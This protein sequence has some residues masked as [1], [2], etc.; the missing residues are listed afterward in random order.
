MKEINYTNLPNFDEF[1]V[2][3]IFLKIKR[4]IMQYIPNLSEGRLELIRH[5]FI[6]SYQLYTLIM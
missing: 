4:I 2:K 1:I 3:N 5:T 6:T